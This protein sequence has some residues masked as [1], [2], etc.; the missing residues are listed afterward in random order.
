MLLGN[1]LKMNS[2]AQ[3]ISMNV[4]IIAAIALIVLVVIS[5]IFIGKSKSF[6]EGAG[7]CEQK[8]GNCTLMG[9]CDGPVIGKMDCSTGKVCCLKV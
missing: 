1:K 4:I 7:S 5:F 9:I 3:G 6:S 2:K 8:Q